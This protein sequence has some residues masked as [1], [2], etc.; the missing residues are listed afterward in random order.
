MVFSPALDWF[1]DRLSRHSPL[2]DPDIRAISELKFTVQRTRA[3][4]DI[5]GPTAKSDHA[6]LVLQ[7]WVA[8]FR[9]LRNGKRQ[10][11]GFSIPGDICNLHWCMHRTLG[12]LSALS[13]G[14]VLNI[15]CDD[16]RR[17]ADAHPLIKDAFWRDCI[18]DAALSV[19]WVTNIGR[20]DA[21][22]RLA[23]L[24]C[25]T[26]V[27]LEQRGLATRSRFVL[28]ASQMQLADALSLTA[29]HVNRTFQALR[30]AGLITPTGLRREIRVDDWDRLADFADFD[31]QLPPF[32]PPRP[33]QSDGP[34]PRLS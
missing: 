5:V 19:E 34:G 23:Y 11:V 25:E 28:D 31:P 7:G 18:L 33:A 6:S 17:L 24:L 2:A 14:L 4:Q 16:L 9:E 15:A 32:G 1:V 8:K 3:N 12:S 20:R 21:A 13:E 10:I 30:G 29:V 26:G 27:R 22:A